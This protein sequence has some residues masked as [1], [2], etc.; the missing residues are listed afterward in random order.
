[1]LGGRN[2]IFLKN[3]VIMEKIKSNSDLKDIIVVLTMKFDIEQ[4]YLNLSDPKLGSHKI[5]ILVSNKYLKTL[6]EL[7]PRITNAIRDY[8]DYRVSCYIA[9]QAKDKILNGNL[10]L[11]TSCVPE[12]LIFKK[13]DSEFVLIPETFSLDKFSKKVYALRNKELQKVDEFKEGYFYY[14]EKEQYSMA[15]F[16]IH[17]AIEL[18]YRYLGIV[19][20]AKER[21][22][23]S[24]RGHHHYL[25]EISMMYDSVF[26][27]DNV[28]DQHLL[29]VLE[30]IYRATRYEDNFD[31]DVET[32]FQLEGK[33]KQLSENA[34]YIYDSTIASFE[35]FVSSRDEKPEVIIED[36]RLVDD[37][38]CFHKNDKVTEQVEKLKCLLPEDVAIYLFGY[39][40]QLFEME[41][42]CE[43]SN[44]G[45]YCLDILIVCHNDIRELVI[46]A[47]AIL[48]GSSDVT[49]LLLSHQ[50]N[51]IQKKLDENNKFFHKILQHKPPFFDCLN[52]SWSFHENNG[53]HSNKELV[54]AKSQWY[55]RKNNALGFFNGG[56]AID[57]CEEVVVKVSLFNQ[58]V[59][60]ACLGLLE[61]F[62]DYRPYQ[63]KLSHLYSLCCSFWHFPNDIFS[64]STV[65]ENRLFKEFVN[66][67][68][69]VRYEGLSYIDWDEAYRYEAR[70]ERFLEECSKIVRETFSES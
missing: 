7:V 5:V 67:V 46:N 56:R 38:S 16:M 35:E 62:Y 13:E 40:T 17:Q 42:V 30:E 50:V 34:V 20:S 15:A 3:T 65:E 36:A 4:I 66:V 59:E 27:E 37:A 58:A 18:T 21:I 68:K 12:R 69:D 1:M 26:D 49:V 41:S 51:Q 9:F 57:S 55:G 70:C 24:I 60:Q 63:H 11:F 53:I 25:K 2:S 19:L 28:I 39:R 52:I 48:N 54:S 61:F 64:R 23:H 33:M 31:I 6:G 14:K 22:K 29:N 43:I 8:P 47:Q 44:Q 10:F 32:L 45:S